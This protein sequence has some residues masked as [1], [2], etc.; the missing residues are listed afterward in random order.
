MLALKVVKKLAADQAF[1]EKIAV[2]RDQQPE[3]GLLEK[4]HLERFGMIGILQT[5]RLQDGFRRLG[6]SS[7]H[8]AEAPRHLLAEQRLQPH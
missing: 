2:A 7:H 6:P 4:A 8:I 5:Q 1:L 3:S